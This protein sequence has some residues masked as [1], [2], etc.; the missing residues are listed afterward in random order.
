MLLMGPGT[1][2]AGE[3]GEMGQAHDLFTKKV[4]LDQVLAYAVQNNPSIQVALEKWRGVVETYRVATAYPDPQLMVTWFPDPIETRLGPQDWNATL[5]QTIPFPGKLATSG[6]VVKTEAAMAKLATDGRVREV[7]ARVARSFHEL[8]YI[9]KALGI[10]RNNAVL[11]DRLRLMA[12]GAHADDRTALVDVVKAQSQVGQLR[13]DMLLLKELEQTEK[14][15]LNSLLNRPPDAAIGEL[16]D[17]GMVTLSC[18]LDTLYALADA[19][20]EGIRIADLEI[21]K[22]K[23]NVALSR[24]SNKPDFKLGL[25]YAAIGEPDVA[26]P[27]RDAGDDAVGIQFGVNIPLWFGK[28]QARIRMARAG[29]ARQKAMKSETVNQTHSTIRSLYFKLN[30]S[31]RLVILYREDLLPQAMKALD[32][33][34]EWFRQGQGSFSDVLEARAAV[35]NFQLSLARAG[36]DHGKTLAELDRLVGGGLDQCRGSSPIIPGKGGK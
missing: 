35:Y 2:H 11:L 3:G 1:L 30:N 31:R 27:P 22:S 14:T 4:V 36:A 8:R 6:E 34:Q 23:L 7:R 17:V 12:E 21:E 15:V 25:F 10:A 20:Q 28:N 16:M 9:Q 24:Y 13:Y 29:I 19:N 26:S 33:S 18:P 32:L 5:S